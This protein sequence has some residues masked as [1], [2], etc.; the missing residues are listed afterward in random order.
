MN[1]FQN[2]QAQEPHISKTRY[3]CVCLR[4]EVCEAQKNGVVQG[5]SPL[6]KKRGK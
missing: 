6:E 5:H 2:T 1:P 4:K 3:V